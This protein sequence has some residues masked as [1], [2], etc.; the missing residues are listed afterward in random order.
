M[1]DDVLTQIWSDPASRW[2]L[3]L[4]GAIVLLAL[5]LVYLERRDTLR[6]EQ[7]RTEQDRR[8]TTWR[9]VDQVSKDERMKNHATR[10]AGS[11]R[12][13]RLPYRSKR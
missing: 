7:D 8:S 11:V 13:D 6:I 9:M 10:A 5:W 12:P 1:P 2:A 3:G 4:L